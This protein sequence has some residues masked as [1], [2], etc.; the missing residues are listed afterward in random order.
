[1]VARFRDMATKTA[2]FFS[3]KLTVI[4]ISENMEMWILK[5]RRRF[6]DFDF[7]KN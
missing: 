3:K 1:M 7:Y 2:L 6:K 5:K 4:H